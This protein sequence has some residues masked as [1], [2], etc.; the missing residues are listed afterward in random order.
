VIKDDE[1][2]G[3]E[4]LLKNDRIGVWEHVV[5]TRSCRTR[6]PSRQRP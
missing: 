1:R 2:L 6:R 5:A 4:L 3:T